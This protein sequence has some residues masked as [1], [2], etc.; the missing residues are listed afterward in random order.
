M[1]R[2][3]VD[4][5]AENRDLHLGRPGV[6]LVGFV[7]A[8]DLGF[9]VSGQCQLAT[10]HARPRRRH[11]PPD[12]R[13]SLEDLGFYL[14]TTA[15]C[16]AP[17]PGR[18]SARAMSEPAASSRRT[19]PSDAPGGESSSIRGSTSRPFW[20]HSTPSVLTRHPGRCRSNAPAGTRR[21]SATPGVAT[22]TPSGTA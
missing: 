18:T 3:V 6:A 5:L 22:A 8:D 15:G 9:L 17:A 21:S 16:K 12:R 14:R 4:A 13:K 2:Q 10:L 7:V 11:T 20:T 1:L 19:G